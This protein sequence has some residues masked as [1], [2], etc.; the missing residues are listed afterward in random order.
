MATA[1]AAT[2]D[3]TNDYLDRGADLTGNADADSGTVVYFFKRAAVGSNMYLY[4]NGGERFSVRFSSGNIIFVEGK[5]TS[6]VEILDLRSSA[7]SDTTNWHSLLCSWDSSNEHLYIDDADDLT[8][9][10][11]D[12]GDIEFTRPNH[13]IWALANG[14]NKFDGD[15]SIVWVNFGQYVDFSVEANRRLFVSSDNKV[16]TN[17]A[18]STDGDIGSLGQPIIFLNSAVPDYESNLGTGGGFTENGTLVSATGPEITAGVPIF[19]RR[20]EMVGAF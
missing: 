14:G 7:L 20:R 3:G 13:G 6:G 9:V 10:T 12:A 1:N 18:A 2:F 16:A 17:L 5:N 15:G 19:R 11:H 8:V 4:Q